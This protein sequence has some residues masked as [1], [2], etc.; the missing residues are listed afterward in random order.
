MNSW[1]YIGY[2]NIVDVFGS[3]HPH[4]SIDIFN[5]ILKLIAS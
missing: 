2:T 3:L 4:H 1:C 5:N